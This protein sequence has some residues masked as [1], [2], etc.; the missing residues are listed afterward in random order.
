MKIR[1]YQEKDKENVRRICYETVSSERLKDKLN[2]VTLMYADFY[3]ETE[4]ENVFVAT[5]DN[6][7][8]IGYVLCSKNAKVYEENWK[9]AYYKKLKKL[10]PMFVLIQKFSVST[11][12]KLEKKGYP[13][14]LH[15]DIDPKAQRL[16]LGTKLIDTLVSHLKSQGVSGVC[17]DCA[18][19]NIK[20][21]AFY[22][23]YGFELLEESKTGN[24][25]G[26]KIE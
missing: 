8:C 22:Q 16:G 21:N 5:N 6:D 26:L 15:I 1:L 9:K 10:N 11:Y 4:P 14:H 19:D 23:K 7:E 18:A 20:G 24:V 12:K 13:A 2:I 17:L 3:L 25:Y